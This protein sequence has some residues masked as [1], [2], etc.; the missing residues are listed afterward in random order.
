MRDKSWERGHP[1]PH[2]A[3][4]EHKPPFDLDLS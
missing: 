1:R 4:R 2:C 3:K